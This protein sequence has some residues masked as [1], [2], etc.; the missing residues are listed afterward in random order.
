MPYFRRLGLHLV[1]S[2]E[3][4]PWPYVGRKKSIKAMAEVFGVNEYVY[5]ALFIPANPD[6]LDTWDDDDPTP[7]DWADH[8][9]HIVK[10]LKEGWEGEED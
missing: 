7:Q 2:K 8:A 3:L 6:G 9:R 4:G 1:D 5:N 10:L